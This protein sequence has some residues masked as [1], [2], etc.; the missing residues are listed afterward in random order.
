MQKRCR[1][2]DFVNA[3]LNQEIEGGLLYGCIFPLPSPQCCFHGIALATSP[4]EVGRDWSQVSA[5]TIARKHDL[6]N[7]QMSKENV[8]MLG[9]AGNSSC[10][11]DT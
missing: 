3:S 6:L 10:R 5:G 11:L 7:L 1:A 8:E 4:E 9:L 2:G